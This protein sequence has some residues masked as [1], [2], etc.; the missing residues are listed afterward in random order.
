MHFYSRPSRFCLTFKLQTG[1]KASPTSTVEVLIILEGESSSPDGLFQCKNITQSQKATLRS[2]K[3]LLLTR[4]ENLGHANALSI[5]LLSSPLRVKT[6]FPA[7]H[8]LV[9]LTKALDPDVE[10]LLRSEICQ[11]CDFISAKAS[12][13]VDIQF[14]NLE[15]FEEQGEGGRTLGV[16]APLQDDPRNHVVV[17]A[18]NR[19]GE[20]TLGTLSLVVFKYRYN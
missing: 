1:V 19:P 4:H 2:V 8:I 6:S 18:L 20:R 11:V 13:D 9:M 5:R 15:A 10:R 14:V 12:S 3:R 17:M 7:G 16:G